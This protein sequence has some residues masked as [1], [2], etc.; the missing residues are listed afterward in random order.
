MYAEGL[1]NVRQLIGEVV[2]YIGVAPTGVGPGPWP[3]QPPH[4]PSLISRNELWQLDAHTER[5]AAMKWVGLPPQNTPE[6]C[7]TLKV[8]RNKWVRL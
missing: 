4:P 5:F 3:E 7:D 8:N 2:E 1:C 6:P